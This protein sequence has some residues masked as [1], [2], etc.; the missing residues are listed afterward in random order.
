MQFRSC[1]TVLALLLALPCLAAGCASPTV[2]G[3]TS[4]IEPAQ[5]EATPE[6]LPPG[7]KPLTVEQDEMIA[8]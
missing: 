4:S 1:R 3:A 2:D 7:V 6:P 5:A 8:Q